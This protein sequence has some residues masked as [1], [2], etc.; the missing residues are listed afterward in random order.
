[1][2]RRINKKLSVFFSSIFLLSISIAC[3]ETP[4]NSNEPNQSTSVSELKA[5]NKMQTASTL[6]VSY[7][8]NTSNEDIADID[9]K[10]PNHS[11][12]PLNSKTMFLYEFLTEEN[13]IKAK[14]IFLKASIVNDISKDHVFKIDSN[15]KY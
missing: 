14:D 8:K 3:G 7:N 10:L 9:S 13:L 15:Y 2:K 11:K 1:M 5:I 6:I 12:K 4:K